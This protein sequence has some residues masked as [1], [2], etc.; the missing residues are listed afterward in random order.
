[1]GDVGDSTAACAVPIGYVGN[2]SDSQP[3]CA[4]NDEDACGVCAG[5]G[6]SLWYEDADGDGQ[7]DA[8]STTA[9]CSQPP[10]YVANSTDACPLDNPNDIDGDGICN[11]A[12]PDQDGDGCANGLDP[13]PTVAANIYT[14]EADIEPLFTTAYG[15]TDCHSSDASWS[16]YLNLSVGSGY[17]EWMSADTSDDSYCSG[18]SYSERV[19]SGNPSNSFLYRKLAGTHDCGDRM[20]QGCT[21]GV[22]CVSDS[23]LALIYMWICQGAPEN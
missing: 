10:G 5:P 11:S 17:A 15:C 6:P 3:D 21:D 20:P 19:I 23:D 2:S 22:D 9:A 18:T 4:S 12:D 13:A 16:G 7:G 1:L 14:Y 8:A